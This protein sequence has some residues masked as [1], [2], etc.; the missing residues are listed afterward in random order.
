MIQVKNG[1]LMN[2]EFSDKAVKTIN[3]LDVT[4]KQR[5]K[6]AILK[7]PDG[8]VRYVKGKKVTTYRLR[9]GD[10]RVVYCFLDRETIF[11]EKIATRGKVYKKGA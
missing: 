6:T 4:T 2:F 5:I 11:I 3:R 9:I 1:E 8:N 7:L 10:W